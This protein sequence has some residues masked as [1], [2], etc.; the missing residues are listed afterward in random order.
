MDYFKCLTNVFNIAFGKTI[1]AVSDIQLACKELIQRQLMT[2]DQKKGLL[3]GIPPSRKDFSMY[4]EILFSLLSRAAL[5]KGVFIRPR[6]I[7]SF[8]KKP[9]FRNLTR[10]IIVGYNHDQVQ[11]VTVNKN[12]WMDTF[13]PCT[14]K[15]V[16]SVPDYFNVTEV[17]TIDC[18]PQYT[19]RHVYKLCPFLEVRRSKIPNA[20]KGLFATRELSK[21]TLL[22]YYTGEVVREFQ[23][24]IRYGKTQPQ[25]VLQLYEDLYVDASNEKESNKLFRF[26]NDPRGSGKKPNCEYTANGGLVTLKKITQNEEL[27]ASYGSGFSIVSYRR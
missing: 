11:L 3:E 26:I 25:Y 4:D 27:L 9:R 14:L 1:L 17:W 8:S 12:I 24:R 7:Y 5:K 16:T 10:Y 23:L 19:D 22:G 13:K 2:E 15:N 20:G 18:S 21:G 6:L